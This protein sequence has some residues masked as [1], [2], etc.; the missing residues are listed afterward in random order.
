MKVVKNLLT[1]ISVSASII[2]FFALVLVLVGYRPFVLSSPSMEP[3]F[4]EGSLCIV[5]TRARIDDIKIG[6]VLVYRT[7]TDLLVLHRLMEIKSKSENTLLA[8]MQGDANNISQVVELS[9][10]NFVGREAFTIPGLG[11]IVEWILSVP[12]IIWCIVGMLVIA[13]CVPWDTI[14]QKRA[15]S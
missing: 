5:N 11:S 12:E 7:S 3:L 2:A 8:E 10:K 6:D 9:A 14:K 4:K 13:S 15:A 1:V